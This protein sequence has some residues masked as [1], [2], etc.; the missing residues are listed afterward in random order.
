[1]DEPHLD[2]RALVALNELLAAN[3][4]LASDL[5]SM[6]VLFRIRDKEL[7][8]LSTEELLS[9][10]RSNVTATFSLGGNPDAA[11]ESLSRRGFAEAAERRA[12][13]CR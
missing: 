7:E 1:M 5:A 3:Y 10:C 2:R 6:R 4:L 9:L 13:R 11:P 12:R 8:P